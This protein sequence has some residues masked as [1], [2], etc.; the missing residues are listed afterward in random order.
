[1]THTTVVPAGLAPGVWQ[2]DTAHSELAFTV[3]HLGMFKV[4]GSFAR[5]TTTI[6]IKPDITDSEVHAEVEMASVDTRDA[7]R[8]THLRSADFFDV[9][10]YPTMTFQS[11]GLSVAGDRVVLSGDL[12]IRGVTRPF[13]LSVESLGVMDQDPMGLRRAGFLA[14][15]ELSRNDFGIAFNIPMGESVVIGNNVQVE[16]EIQ[17]FREADG[18]SVGSEG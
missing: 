12:T 17:A 11:T 5:F 1:M 7:N 6:I 18:D 14:K 9:E 16:L 2:I 8:D 4:R 13:E 10:N 15:G 3:R